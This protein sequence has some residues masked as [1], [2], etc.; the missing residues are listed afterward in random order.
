MNPI[1]EAV[2]WPAC[3]A[4][5]KPDYTVAGVSDNLLPAQWELLSEWAL[6]RPN[7]ELCR[8]AWQDIVPVWTPWAQGLERWYGFAV[9]ALAAVLALVLLYLFTP[10]R[11]WRKPTLLN[12]LAWAGASWL[13]GVGMLALLHTAGLQRLLYPTVLSLQ[14][15]NSTHTQWLNIGRDARTAAL[16]LRDYDTTATGKQVF[17]GSEEAVHARQAARQAQLRTAPQGKYLTRQRLNLRAE[18]GIQAQLLRVLAAGETV[19]YGGRREQ[20]WW[21]VTAADG[22]SGWVSSLWLRQPEE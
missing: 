20:D 6:Q 19:A 8:M 15:P 4:V 17:D 11:W 2:D 13:L 16:Y 1:I 9:F 14:M 12:M 7:T 22:Q 21:Y 5:A 10:K 3:E 18:P